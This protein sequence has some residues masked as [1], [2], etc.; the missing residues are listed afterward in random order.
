MALTSEQETD[1]LAFMA[2]FE[3]NKKRISDLES[4]VTAQS[5]HLLPV[6]RAGATKNISVD[7]I[8]DFV[9]ANF[10]NA[11]TTIKGA[12]ELLTNAELAAGTDTTRAA[13]ASAIASLFGA[14]TLSGNGII[15]IPVKVGTE[16]KEIIIQ[17]GV[18]HNVTSAGITVTLHTAFPNAMIRAFLTPFQFSSGTVNPASAQIMAGANS[19]TTTNF[20]ISNSSATED[21]SWQWMAIGY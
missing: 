18:A 13:T 3:D 16:I 9:I 11:S 12:L 20:F 19:F 15:R 8:K 4:A 10:P 21:R 14:S 2:N 6:E 1:L 17:M 5:D 7:D